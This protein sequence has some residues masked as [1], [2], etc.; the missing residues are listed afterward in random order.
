MKLV[1]DSAALAASLDQALITPEP[2]AS[3]ASLRLARERALSPWLERYEAI[4]RSL[5][6]S[7]AR[8]A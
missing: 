8:N 5:I 4:Y 3:A 7:P 1:I 2:R 6:P